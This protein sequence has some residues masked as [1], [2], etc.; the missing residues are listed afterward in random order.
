MSPAAWQRIRLCKGQELNRSPVRTQGSGHPAMEEQSDRKFA[1]A[2]STTGRKMHRL[3]VAQTLPGENREESSWITVTDYSIPIESNRFSDG[4][5]PPRHRRALLVRSSDERDL[6][7]RPSRSWP[8]TQQ[9]R[10][11]FASAISTMRTSHAALSE[12]PH[13]TKV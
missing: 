10:G 12:C 13:V 9:S 4:S 2:N 5:S 3:L 7:R 11:E 6:Q 8:S 1:S